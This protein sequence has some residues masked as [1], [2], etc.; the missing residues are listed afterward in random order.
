MIK[1][2]QRSTVDRFEGYSNDVSPA[3][4]ICTIMPINA[5]KYGHGEMRNKKL[6]KGRK[7]TLHKD[8]SSA[9]LNIALEK[10]GEKKKKNVITT[11]G[12]RIWSPIRVL[13][14]S[15]L[16]LLLSL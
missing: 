8:D 10:E 4:F 9:V 6:A 13:T 12:I 7:P 14:L 3:L 1:C 5:H 16:N 15:E 11:R 2:F